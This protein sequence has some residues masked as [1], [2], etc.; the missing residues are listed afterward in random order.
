MV[1]DFND[2]FKYIVV[3]FHWKGIKRTRGYLLIHYNKIK[4]GPSNLKKYKLKYKQL[5][6]QHYMNVIKFLTTMSTSVHHALFAG[7][8]VI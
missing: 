5:Q 1:N 7:E 8:G 6:K 3:K 4:F 2:D